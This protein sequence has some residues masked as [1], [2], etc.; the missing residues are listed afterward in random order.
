[1]PLYLDLGSQV[2]DE[3]TGDFQSISVVVSQG[4]LELPPQSVSV[5]RG[6]LGLAEPVKRHRPPFSNRK[7][8][9]GP[10]RV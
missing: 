1:M 8:L 10:D 7:G 4:L 3:D 6:G 2:G 9:S 5:L